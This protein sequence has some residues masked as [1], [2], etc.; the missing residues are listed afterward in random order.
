MKLTFFTF[1]IGWLA[2]AGVPPLSGF[3]AKG[4][5]LDNAFARYPVLWAVGLI[6]AGLTAYYMSRLM[7][8]AFFGDE[9]W[10]QVDTRD[11]S[12]KEHAVHEPHESPWVMTLPLV[13]LSVFAL[14]GGLLSLPGHFSFDPLGWLDPVFG[15]AL[16]DAHQSGGTQWVL[17]VVDALVALG[18]LGLSLRIW[19]R[20][21]ENP[22]LEPVFFKK[23]W[24]L[25][26]IY[27]AIIAKPGLVLAYVAA[28]TIDNGVIDG[29]VRGTATITRKAGSALRKVQTG[30]V[31][32]YALGIVLGL[33]LLFGYVATRAW[34]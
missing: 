1:L 30:F 32:Q 6:T 25:D 24:F 14:L 31:R 13:V 34:L 17:G 7:A 22:K 27:D 29:A 5:V 8:L 20:S 2:I 9:R 11:K 21:A 23:S 4:D 3:F 16:Y 28:T 33:V 10:R 12:S 26:D 19:T 15:H 18:G